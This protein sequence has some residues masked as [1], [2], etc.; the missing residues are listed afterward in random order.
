MN[1]PSR[2]NGMALLLYVQRGCSTLALLDNGVIRRIRTIPVGWTPETDAADLNV[3]LSERENAALRGFADRLRRETSLVL[4][5]A[6]FVPDRLLAYGEAFLGNGA[7]ARFAEAFELPVSVLGQEVPLAGQVARLGETD[8]SRLLALCVAAM[9]LPAPWRPP[10]FPSFHRP[11][12]GGHL[13]SEHGRR[14]AW[15]ACGALAVGAACLASVWAEGYAAG[16]QAVRHEDAA[17]SL[18]RKALPD[19]R[20]SFNPVQMESILKNRIAGLR[21]GGEN[22]ATFPA[23]HL[24]QDMHAAVPDSL[25]I[26]LDRLSL[27]ARRCGLSGTAASYE[28]VNALRVAL[29][30]L[31]GVREAKILSA[32]SRTGKPEPGTPSG[33]VIFEIELALEGGQS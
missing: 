17:R 29:S 3:S 14:L 23:L 20:G 26:R 32:A 10:L 13:S 22:D 12:K 19:V 18:F 30:G 24:L 21:G 16:Q 5:G 15:A 31:P 27:D 1:L 25:D 8:P 11:P 28:Q 4:D 6:P 7:S 9:P 2:Q 33:A